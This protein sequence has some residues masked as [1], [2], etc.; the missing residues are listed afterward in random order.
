MEVECGVVAARDPCGMA[1]SLGQGESQLQRWSFDPTSLTCRP[2]TYRGLK[3][4]QNNFLSQ[5]DCERTCP[6]FRNPCAEG[7]PAPGSGGRPLQCAAR[8]PGICPRGYWL[9][10]EFIIA[11]N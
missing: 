7:P 8:Q 2:F 5:Q 11:E 9:V 3:G 6:V 1:M 4:N 10:L